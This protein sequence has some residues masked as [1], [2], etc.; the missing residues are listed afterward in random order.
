MIHSRADVHRVVRN[1]ESPSK[2]ISRIAPSA[3]Y[4]Q[5]SFQRI[6]SHGSKPESKQPTSLPMSTTLLFSQAPLPLV[7]KVSYEGADHAQYEIETQ[8]GKIQKTTFVRKLDLS[9]WDP[10]SLA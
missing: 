9:T 6:N 7:T 3:D 8:A 10:F 2:T 5:R 1:G 4:S